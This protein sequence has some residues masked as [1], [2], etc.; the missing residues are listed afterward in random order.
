MD[1]HDES[2]ATSIEYALMGSLI[3]VVIA[4][5]VTRLGQAL[6]TVFTGIATQMGWT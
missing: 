3:A 1:V 2:G 6:T 5:S 4:L